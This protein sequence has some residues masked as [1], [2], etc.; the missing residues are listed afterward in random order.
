MHITFYS[1]WMTI[2]WSS[3]LI[4]IFY[5]LRTKYKL[6]DICSVSGVIV[7][8]L[9]CMIRMVIPAEFPWTKILFG[10]ALYN[11]IYYLFCV[12]QNIGNY[13]SVFDMMRLVWYTGSFLILLHYV[14]QYVKLARY[15]GE[16]PV[17]RSSSAT[18]IVDCLYF[19]TSAAI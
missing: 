3:I 5:V 8:Y 4:L 10:G 9:F 15:F 17:Q 19:F 16:M 7:L 12:E 2:L 13:I 1:F 11:R 14:I 18:Q 6:I